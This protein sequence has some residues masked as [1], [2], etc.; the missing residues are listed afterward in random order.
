MTCY[1]EPSRRLGDWSAISRQWLS[2]G[3][4]FCLQDCIETSRKDDVM[5]F[6]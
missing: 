4:L 3:G 5:V 2:E 1:S 6:S